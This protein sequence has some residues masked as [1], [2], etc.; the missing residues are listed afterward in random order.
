MSFGHREEN[1]VI[2]GL[3]PP[4]NDRDGAMRIVGGFGEDLEEQ[5]FGDVVGAGARNEEA[6]ALEYLNG[7]KVDFLVAAMG[8]GDAVAVLGESGRV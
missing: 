4:L 7:A 8:G 3:C 2:F 5:S 1:G 6:A